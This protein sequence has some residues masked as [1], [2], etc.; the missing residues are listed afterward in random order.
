MRGRMGIKSRKG[1]VDKGAQFAST[2]TVSIYVI[3]ICSTLKKIPYHLK[4]IT[5]NVS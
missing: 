2:T 3:K 4:G 1:T 5:K